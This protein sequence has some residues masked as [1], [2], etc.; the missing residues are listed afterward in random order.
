MT[1]LQHKKAAPFLG[2]FGFWGLFGP[3]LATGHFGRMSYDFWAFLAKIVSLFKRG[4]GRLVG[5]FWAKK[6]VSQALWVLKCSRDGFL[7][8]FGPFW[9]KSCICNGVILR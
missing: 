1:P 8:L 4:R 6:A 2:L 9:P 5:A 3:F 7:A